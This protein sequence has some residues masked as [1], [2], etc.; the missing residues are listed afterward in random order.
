LAILPTTEAIKVLQENS[1]ETRRMLSDEQYQAQT[2]QSV[3]DALG[4]IEQKPFDAYVMDYKLP[5]GS[6]L[7]V[8]ERKPSPISLF[9]ASLYRFR[10]LTIRGFL[11]NR[12]S[13]MFSFV[14]NAGNF[15]GLIISI[16]LSKIR[17]CVLS[18]IE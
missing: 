8:A 7:D 15:P 13:S 3:F 10:V 4:A 12:A 9:G 2:S 14:M 18:D 16:R 1:D 5:D 17:T 11:E 6:G